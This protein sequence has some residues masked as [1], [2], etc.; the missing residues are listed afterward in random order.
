MGLSPNLAHTTAH[1]W[2]CKNTS[3]WTQTKVVEALN[4]GSYDLIEIRLGQNLIKSN[5]VAT[6]HSKL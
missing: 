5:K 4:Y 3:E 1:I 2:T 6:S